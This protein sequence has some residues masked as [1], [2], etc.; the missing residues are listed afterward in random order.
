MDPSNHAGQDMVIQGDVGKRG[1][2]DAH[3]GTHLQD[4]G[5]FYVLTKNCRSLASSD[6]FDELQAELKGE[7]W[8]VVL[9]NETWRQQEVEYWKTEDKHIFAARGHES[10]RRG[11]GILLH[12]RWC[13]GVEAFQPVSE[14]LCYLDVKIKGA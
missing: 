14:R 10:G 11:V 7:A 12:E 8:D 6:R 3:T 13:H 2:Q 4:C 5:L 9:L 1:R